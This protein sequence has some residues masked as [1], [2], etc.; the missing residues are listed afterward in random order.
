MNHI[1]KIFNYATILGSAIVFNACA[2]STIVT[3][4]YSIRSQGVDAA[5]E[6]SGWSQQVNL[7]DKQGAYGTCALTTEYTRSFN[8]GRIAQSLFGTNSCNINNCTGALINVAGSRVADRGAHDLLADYFYLPTDFQ[9]T[10]QFNPRIQNVV[11]DINFYVGLDNVVPGLFLRLDLPLNWSS[12]NVGFCETV[13]QAGTNNYDAGYF[14]GMDVAPNGAIAGN[15]GIGIERNKLLTSF[16]QY[17][18]GKVPTD[19]TNTIFNPLCAAKINCRSHSVTRLADIQAI[20]G[21][22]FLSCTDYHVGAGILTRAPTGNRPTGEFLFEPIS[23]NGGSWELGAHITCH[24]TLWQDELQ[25]SRLGFYADANITHVFKAHQRRTFDMHCKPLGRYMLAQ[26]F[27]TPVEHLAGGIISSTNSG[28]GT[29]IPSA[30]FA[31]E[32]SPVANLSTQEVRVS[33]A[34]QADIAAQFTYVMGGWSWDVGYNFWGRSC[35][36]FSFDDCPA[37]CFNS[38]NSS[39]STS[40]NNVQFADNTWGVKGDAYVVG[41]DTSTIPATAVALSATE[42]CATINHGT[43]FPATGAITASQIQAGQLNPGVDNRQFAF[44]GNGST[45]PLY[46]DP[47]GLIGQT[48]TSVDPVL[49]SQKNFNPIGTRGISNKIYTHLS[50]SWP[51]CDIWTPYLGVGAFGEF[52]SSGFNSTCNNDCATTCQTQT[53]ATNSCSNSSSSNCSKNCLSSSL[54]QWGVFIKGGVSFN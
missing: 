9:S 42:S 20:V 17:A 31:N 1:K 32:F 46:A 37:A 10:L 18:C 34:I 8:A 36:K 28:T 11:F 35:E 12:W 52:G 40:C 39:C 4:Y 2:S 16:G 49:L 5:R 23:G 3:P 21:W 7:F 19:T 26:K 30:Q 29:T 41:F 38:C 15:E 51:L 50:Y 43:N 44:N 27:T 53:T 33:I 45:V 48:Q 47:L 22:N 6:L 14:N 13:S 25:E 54:S 24:A